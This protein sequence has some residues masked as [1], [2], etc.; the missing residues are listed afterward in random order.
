MK[1]G[2]KFR[3]AWSAAASV[4]SDEE[5]GQLFKAVLAFATTGE[6][7]ALSGAALGIFTVIAQV[8]REDREREAEIS[9]IR[10]AAGA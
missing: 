1:D 6:A 7:P 5:A 2:F 9:A 8:L 4:L 10:S 3:M